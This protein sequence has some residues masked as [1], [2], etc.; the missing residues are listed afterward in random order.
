MIHIQKKKNLKKKKRIQ[1]GYL[2]TSFSFLLGGMRSCVVWCVKAPY[3]YKVVQKWKF[4]GRQLGRSYDIIPD[5][6]TPLS[7]TFQHLPF[8][9]RGKTNI[10]P[11][12]QNSS[13][14]K[15]KG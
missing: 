11:Q 8:S 10:L 15:E 6:V 14:F 5:H 2:D 4:S 7:K 13:L 12:V 9:F 3:N 1:V